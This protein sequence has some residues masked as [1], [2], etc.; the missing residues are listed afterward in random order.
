MLRDEPM[1][2]GWIEVSP[3]GDLLVRA[4]ATHADRDALVLPDD[5]CTYGGL[6]EGARHTAR[7]LWALGVRPGDHVGLLMPNSREFAEAFFAISLMGCV[8][9]PINARYKLA[10]LGYVVE[11]ADLTTV[12]TSDVIEEHVDFTKV[13]HT[14]LP[15]LASNADPTQLQL[16]E[17]P[18]L[19]AAVMLRGEGKD[20]FLGRAAFD[21]LATSADARAVDELRHRV[22]VRDVATILYTSGTTARP[23]GCMLTHEALSR[24]SVSR[25]RERLA[26]GGHDV[27]WSAGPLF[28]IGSLQLF[29]GSVGIAGTYLADVHFDPGRALRMMESER[30]TSAWPWF[31]AITQSLLNEPTFDPDALRSLRT[32]MLIGPTA[33]LERVQELL[34]WAKL[35]NACGMTETAG[36]YAISDPG[37]SNEQRTCTGGTPVEGMEVRIVD[38]DTGCDLPPGEIGEILVRGYAVMDGYYRDPEK[39]AE[40][41]DADGWLHTHDLYVQRTTGHLTFMGRSKDM[42]KVGG[43]NVAAVEIE[44][45]LAEH[46]AVKLAEVVGVPDPRLDEVPIAFVELNPGTDLDAD[47]LIDFCRGRIAAW[48]IPRAVHLIEAAEWPM[49]ATKVD[50]GALRQRLIEQETTATR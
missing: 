33:L 30:V 50:K 13:L 44:A 20:G 3:V 41:L 23:K 34:P 15:S 35:L 49:S 21:D 40:S 46:P 38:V 42:L 45:F 5:R 8:V 26:V 9:V 36:A 48:K 1:T 28:H 10:E 12:L 47:E 16:P 43:E 2:A 31:P 32:L 19:R 17:A 11:N 22:R 37:D 4:A 18:R 6:L 25:V 14:S 24:G 29:I 27:F 7:G 39:T